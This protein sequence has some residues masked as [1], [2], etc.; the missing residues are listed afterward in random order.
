MSFAFLK[1]DSRF[2]ETVIQIHP[3]NLFINQFLKT[4]SKI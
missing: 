2:L 1:T 3:P 4:I